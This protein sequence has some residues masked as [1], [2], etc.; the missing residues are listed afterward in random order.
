MTPVAQQH[1]SSPQ[2]LF[3]DDDR[4][5]LNSVVAAASGLG[6]E[7]L[8]AETADEGM[9]FVRQGSIDA[10]VCDWR[11]PGRSGIALLEEVHQAAPA[12]PLALQTGYAIGDQENA[13]LKRIG[14]RTFGKGTSLE[15]V[16]ESLLTVA[17]AKSS[18]VQSLREE[19]KALKELNRELLSDLKASLLQ[20]PNPEAAVIDDGA[21]GAHSVAELIRDIEEQNT[22]G[23]DFVRWWLKARS[24]LRSLGRRP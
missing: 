5:Y 16:L 11:M 10:M 13:R 6:V 14:A 9:S 12:L 15:D 19:N 7:V 18:E 17:S 8:T 3:V 23:R 2:V 22:R 24:R 21:G 1:R 20:I 4:N